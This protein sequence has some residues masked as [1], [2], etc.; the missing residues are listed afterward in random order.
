MDGVKQVA[1]AVTV[2]LNQLPPFCAPVDSIQPKEHSRATQGSTRRYSDGNGLYSTMRLRPSLHGEWP[3][4][5]PAREAFVFVAA[6]EGD[7]RDHAVDERVGQE[8]FLP[9]GVTVGAIDEVAGEQNIKKARDKMKEGKRRDS[10]CKG[11]Q[12]I[13]KQPRVNA[14]E[15][16]TNALFFPSGV[17]S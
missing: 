15:K 3:L 4:H 13:E 1:P 17:P 7:R 2:E 6:G 14:H 11:E 16:P 5:I 9:Y 12:P 10:T 8:S